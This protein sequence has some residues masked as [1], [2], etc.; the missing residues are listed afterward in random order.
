MGIFILGINF[1]LKC[2]TFLSFHLKRQ[3]C[4]K[5]LLFFLRMLTLFAVDEKVKYR[6]TKLWFSGLR[7]MI[8]S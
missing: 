2:L 7:I 8:F 5:R 1:K 3:T 4:L 6:Y